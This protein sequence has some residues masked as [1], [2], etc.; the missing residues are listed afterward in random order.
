MFGRVGGEKKRKKE[1]KR[2]EE[3]EKRKR[4][5]RGREKTRVLL[6]ENFRVKP[7]KKKN[8]NMFAASFFS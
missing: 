8:F 3:E 6:K 4:E 2:R 5:R 1:R 7:A